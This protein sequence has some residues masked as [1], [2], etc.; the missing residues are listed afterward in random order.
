MFPETFDEEPIPTTAFTL[1]P[2]VQRFWTPIDFRM[3]RDGIILFP[4]AILVVFVAVVIV[5]AAIVIVAV[6]IV[7]VG[8]VSIRIL[9]V[10]GPHG[11]FP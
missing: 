6:V 2:F 7:V 4:L 10:I 3:I 11:P 5:V 9:F 8:G 1:A